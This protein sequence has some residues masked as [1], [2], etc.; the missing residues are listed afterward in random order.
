[1][2]DTVQGNMQLP[3]LRSRCRKWPGIHIVLDFKV[4]DSVVACCPGDTTFARNSHAEFAQD[5][6]AMHSYSEYARFVKW[7]T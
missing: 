2:W 6:T 5:F 4:A 7:P 1:M 3:N